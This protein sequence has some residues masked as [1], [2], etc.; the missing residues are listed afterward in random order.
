M[1]NGLSVA[2]IE[3]LLLPVA[4]LVRLPDPTP[5]RQPHYGAFLA[6]T[7]RPV[8]VPH[9]GTLASR[10]TPL[11]LPSRPGHFSPSPSQNRTRQSPVIR[12]VHLPH[13]AGCTRFPRFF[14]VVFR[15]TMFLASVPDPFAPRPLQP[16]Q[17]YYGSVRPSPVHR[18]FRPRCLPSRLFSYHHWSGSQVP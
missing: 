1:L 16:L 10:F 3:V 8:P 4:S 18:Y 11:G 2:R 14:P 5:S 9:I 7:N 6:T 12:L 15:L 17:H 13:P